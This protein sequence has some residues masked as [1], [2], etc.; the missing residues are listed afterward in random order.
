MGKR[1]Y[2][3]FPILLIFLLTI[4]FAWGTVS[5]AEFSG[6]I[7]TITKHDT[8]T[9]QIFVKGE[10]YRMEL[11]QDGEEI[12]VIVDP[13]V[14]KTIVI[15]VST[16]IYRELASD[17]MMSLMNDP[18]QA[19]LY[20]ADMG[21]E[22]S[23]G[24]ETIEG[25]ECDK[26][27]VSMMDSDVMSEWV[28][29]DLNFPIKIVT[30]GQG[31]R[32]MTVTDIKVAS[33][34]DDKFEVPEGYTAW[35]DPD[36]VPGKRPDWADNIAAAPLLIPPF[37]MDLKPGNTVRV[38]VE[39]GKSL[40]VKGVSD[41]DATARVIP[42]KG[43]N[44]LKDEDRYNNFAQKGTLCDRRHEM[45]GEADEFIIHVYKGKV[46]VIAK[47]QKMFEKTASA[48]EV[49]RFPIDGTE[50]ITTRIINLTDGSA[51]AMFAYYQD[52]QPMPD[53]DEIPEKYR[54]IALEKPWD[55]NNV[56]RVAKGDEFVITVHEGT[57]QIKLGQF[58][59]F[60]F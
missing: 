13:S 26:S 24:T 22:S 3:G 37:E 14:N 9:G 40:F 51:R 45:N 49:V 44:P 46:N 29:K 58:D 7:T 39:P 19:Y 27:K 23:A 55:V 15:P 25:Y 48:G 56:T 6:K 35:I 50:H 18:I 53:N 17:D 5:A 32:E 60:E 16:G 1:I 10:K 54:T 52:G 12:I 57:M 42:F 59:S 43:E 41:G 21:E 8:L 28:A 34:A 20:T 2:P 11:T 33:V 47:W 36:S 4:I 31:A 38:K 30:Y